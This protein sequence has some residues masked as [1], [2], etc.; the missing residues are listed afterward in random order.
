MISF[1][2]T[3]GVTACFAVLS[4]AG[5]LARSEGAGALNT[6]GM[7][8][9]V[10][11]PTAESFEDAQIATSIALMNGQR[12]YTLGFQMTPRITGAFRYATIENYRG[13]GRTNYDRSFDLHYRLVDEGQLRPA[14]A[15]G[16]RDFVGTG[17]FSSEYIVASKQLTPGV[18][19]SGGIGWGKLGGINSFDNPLGFLGNRFN[20]RQGR[21]DLGG[22]PNSNQW[23]RG[24][25][26]FFA[27][28]RWQI[29]DRMALNFEYSSDDYALQDGSGIVDPKTPFNFGLRYEARPGMV[30]GAQY[31]NGSTLGF[32]AHFVL[33]PRHPP[34]GGDMSPA[35]IPFAVRDGSAAS[36]AGNVI[37]DAI[38][39]ANRTEALTALLAQEGLILEQIEM[40]NT[41]VRIRIRNTRHDSMPQ[42]IGRAARMLALTMPAQIE[43]FEIEPVENGVP[44][45]QVALQRA[46]LER[47][48]YAPDAIKSGQA[49]M[50][51]GPAGSLH[52]LE[53]VPVEHLQWAI[54]PFIGLSLFD[55][56]NPL[57]ADLGLEVTASYEFKPTFSVSAVLR[58]KVIG[59]RDTSTRVSTSILPHVRSDQPLY[60]SGGDIWVDRLT[61]DH[62]GQVGSDVYTRLSLGYLEEMFG[63]VSGEVLWK[64]VTSRLALGAE[65]N[66]AMQRDTDKMFGF[67]E[68]DYDV[69]TGHV[70]GYYA[71]PN[72]LD[73]QVDL[74]RY[75]AGDWGTTIGLDRRFGNGWSVG[76]FATLTDVPFDD[77]GEGSF[78]KGIRFTVPMSWLLGQPSRSET[79]LTI[80]PVQRDGGA[81]LEINNRLY[82]TVRPYHAPELADQWGRFWR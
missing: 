22:K 44:L 13:S 70:S 31:L 23:F 52:G 81:R 47:L 11:M 55:P 60:D 7:P 14:V 20:S 78:D 75:L 15:V 26:A 76:V 1:K 58:G 19:V 69:V 73:L 33:N 10:D 34:A 12:K 25:A 21:N 50:S 74:G 79:G 2:W 30:L 42:A 9:L 37:Q 48:D 43:R 18:H 64:P 17:L 68:Y 5:T 61:L 32:S 59:N 77:F 45:S 49:A 65:I 46:D 40:R 29:N 67:G 56:D 51:I 71:L 82:E 63:G 8:G 57:R 27:G 80:R 39:Q 36:W 41:L 38:P 72:G 4:S 66:Y 24:P 16:L 6:Y 3:L 54:Q 28:A 53:T 35:P 62:F